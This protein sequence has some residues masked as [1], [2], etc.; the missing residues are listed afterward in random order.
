[1]NSASPIDIVVDSAC[2]SISSFQ[3]VI[4]E[5]IVACEIKLVR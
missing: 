2:F 4:K 1:M 3:E 5:L